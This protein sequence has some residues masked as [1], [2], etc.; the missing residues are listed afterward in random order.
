[1]CDFYYIGGQALH[2]DACYF[3][4]ENFMCSACNIFYIRQAGI[5]GTLQWRQ[6]LFSFLKKINTAHSLS[7]KIPSQGSVHVLVA[8]IPK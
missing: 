7:L 8:Y 4:L 6:N 5:Y 2:N 3:P 1:M